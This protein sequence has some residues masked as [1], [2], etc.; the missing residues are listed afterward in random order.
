MPRRAGAA[1]WRSPGGDAFSEGSVSTEVKM[2][3]T[4]VASSFLRRKRWKWDMVGDREGEKAMGSF[5]D[6][7]ESSGG[8]VRRW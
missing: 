6:N 1:G 2:A 8:R 5:V 7:R 3:G 4:A